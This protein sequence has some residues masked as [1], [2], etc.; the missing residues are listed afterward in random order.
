MFTKRSLFAFAAG[1]ASSAMVAITPLREFFEPVGE[2]HVYLA[3]SRLED[4]N[5]V[6]TWRHSVDRSWKMTVVWS[7]N[8]PYTERHQLAEN[9]YNSRILH[10]QHIS[11]QNQGLS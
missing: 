6:E 2:P 9:M 5:E 11:A 3:A 4:A 8:V 7:P 10:V 1:A